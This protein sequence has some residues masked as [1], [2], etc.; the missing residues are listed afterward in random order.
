MERISIKGLTNKQTK[1]KKCFNESLSL[2]EISI[3]LV[4]SEN[5]CGVKVLK[6]KRKPYKQRRK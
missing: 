3:S 2:L 6:S 4:S 5:M 1:F